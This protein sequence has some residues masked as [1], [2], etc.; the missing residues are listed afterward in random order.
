M[1]ELAYSLEAHVKD[2]FVING[3]L[4]QLCLE[5]LFCSIVQPVEIFDDLVCNLGAILVQVK[6]DGSCR[7]SSLRLDDA[8]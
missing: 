3:S 4:Y 6:G 5:R 2:K 8:F 7:C 1:E